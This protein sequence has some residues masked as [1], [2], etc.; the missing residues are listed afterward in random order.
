MTVSCRVS[1]DCYRLVGGVPVAFPNPGLVRVTS[2]RGRIVQSFVA[3]SCS[4]L[5][6]L[7]P[8]GTLF[9]YL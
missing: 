1:E 8:A 2:C 7:T 9:T 6:Q 3:H 5:L 4:G